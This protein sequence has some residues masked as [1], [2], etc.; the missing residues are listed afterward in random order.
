[1]S[2]FSK[3]FISHRSY[4][5]DKAKR[6]RNYLVNHN[7][8]DRVVLW[9]EESL[10]RNDEQ[11]TVHDYFEAIERI[12]ESMK[13][14]S[15]F[16]YIDSPVFFNGFFT[17]AEVLQWRRLHD[18][19]CLYKVWYKDNTYYYEKIQLAPLTKS[20][21]HRLGLTS[22]LCSPDRLYDTEGGVFL[23][24]WGKY[25]TECFL[26]SCCNCGKYY[27]ITRK[28]MNLYTCS[29][30]PAICP[31]CNCPHAT[32]VKDLNGKKFFGTRIPIIAR[33]FVRE[34]SDHMPITVDDV[35]D[36]MNTKKLPERFP[37]DKL[38]NE[39][40][41]SDYRKNFENTIKFTLK[42]LGVIGTIGG[43]YS[44]FDSKE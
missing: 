34:I 23:D 8:A 28:K 12:K 33:P 32:F 25:A 43:I 9:E 44:F 27:L 22:Y 40:L 20:E 39:K 38:P 14:C 4:D 42:I 26:I 15:A 36:L 30:I 7:I 17:G 10:C 24:S 11:L 18:N 31:H 35:L 1:M 29:P 37:L 41:K 3:V 5:R 16:L 2:E 19:P 6:F 21:R 13:S